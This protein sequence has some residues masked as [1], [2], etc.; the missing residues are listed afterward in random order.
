MIDITGV[1]LVE[2]AKKVYEFSV[3]QGLG[4]FRF[5][6]E[7][8]TDSEAKQLIQEN[9]YITLD[10][11]YVRRRACKMTVWKK[12]DKLEIAD[13]WYDHTNRIFKRLLEFFGIEQPEAIKHNI[14]CN[15]IDCQ[16][17][18]TTIQNT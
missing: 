7:P 15:C 1:D 14:A 17:A 10:M 8:L 3:P 11:D 12:G 16:S 4:A 9:R 6:P 13:R 5:T 2:F 18:R